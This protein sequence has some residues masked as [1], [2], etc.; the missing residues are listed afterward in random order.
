MKWATL[1]SVSGKTIVMNQLVGDT[2][3]V[4]FEGEVYEQVIDEDKAESVTVEKLGGKTIVWNQLI[5]PVNYRGSK[6]EKGLTVTDNKDGTITLN[7]TTEG[8]VSSRIQAYFDK[9]ATSIFQGHKYLIPFIDVSVGLYARIETVNGGFNVTTPTFTSTLDGTFSCDVRMDTGHTYTNV[10][11]P[12]MVFDLTTM[13]GETIA[14]SMTAEQFRQLF[15]KDYYPY[16]EPTLMSFDTKEVVSRGANL[17]DLKSWYDSIAT[18]YN[19]NG[20]SFT[21]SESEQCFVINGT[22]TNTSM[23]MSKVLDTPL[24][25]RSGMVTGVKYLGGTVSKNDAPYA[26]FYIG[27]SATQQGSSNWSTVDLSENDGTKQIPTNGTFGTFKYITRVWLYISG[28]VTFSN[29][30]MQPIIAYNSTYAPYRDPITIPIPESVRT[31]YPL[32]SAGT[33]YDTI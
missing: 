14:N 7:G 25:Y 9:G 1:D 26:I 20:L 31:Q 22:S 23:F 29:Y 4:P 24:P 6:V 27:G 19:K 8:L 15:P 11:I 13:F 12:G 30:K 21:Y 3:P 16:S 28:G 32:R 5:N 10:T 33:V 18:E 17:L 2:Y